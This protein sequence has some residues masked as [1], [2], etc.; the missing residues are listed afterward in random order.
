MSQDIQSPRGG[1]G[2]ISLFVISA[3]TIAFLRYLFVAVFRD[4]THW[5][6]VAACFILTA[7]VVVVI[8]W[9]ARKHHRN[10]Y[11]DIEVRVKAVEERS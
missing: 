1:I 2:A 6:F 5:T 9:Q 8:E 4:P 3:L 11:R 7:L 10:V